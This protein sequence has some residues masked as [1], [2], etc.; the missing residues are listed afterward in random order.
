MGQTVSG[1]NSKKIGHSESETLDQGIVLTSVVIKKREVTVDVPRVVVTD[2]EYERPV[3]KDRIY[4]RPVVKEVPVETIR[5]IP[6]EVETI[7]YT[8]KEVV[9]EKPVIVDKE[10][11]RPVIKEQIYEKPVIENKKVEVVTVADLNSLK[12]YVTL[13]KELK[14]LLPELQSKLKEVKE[15]KL[16]EKVITVPKLEYITTQVERI[17]W[18]DVKREHPV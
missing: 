7:H 12:E 2:K 4:E 9:Y 16:I 17:E 6:K 13:L 1:G 8:P 3:V 5:Y 14:V 15:Y 18:V 11:E 10:Y